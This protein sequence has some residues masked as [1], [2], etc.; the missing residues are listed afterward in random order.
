[1]KRSITKVEACLKSLAPDAP[2][3]VFVRRALDVVHAGVPWAFA[4]L[5][6]ALD[7]WT[8]LVIVDGEAAR[9]RRGQAGVTVSTETDGADVFCVTRSRVIVDLLHGRDGL[10]EAL[11]GERIELRGGIDAILSFNNVLKMFLHGAVRARA[12]DDLRLSFEARAVIKAGSECLA[13][14]HLA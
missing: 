9:I 11:E 5:E 6:Q 14:T 4:G 8:A 3:S 7:G 13:T 1:V 10:V 12:F 2:F